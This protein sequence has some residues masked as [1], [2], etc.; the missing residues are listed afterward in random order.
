M[1][2]DFSAVV[3]GSD[4]QALD[5][6]WPQNGCGEDRKPSRHEEC[7][8]V[9]VIVIDGGD[10]R[11]KG[12]YAQGNGEGVEEINIANKVAVANRRG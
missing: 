7:E 10:A 4:L 1:Q 11:D 6:E 3:G 5:A 9:L 8:N 2:P 12:E